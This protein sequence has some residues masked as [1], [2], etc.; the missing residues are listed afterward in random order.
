[1]KKLLVCIL[2]FQFAISG[3]AQQT[4][5]P[6]AYKIVVFA[7]VFIDSA[8][9]GNTYKINGNSL[10]KTILPGLDFYNGVMMAVDSLQ[11]EKA[12]IEVIFYDTKSVAE[13][14]NKVLSQKVWDIVSLIVVSFKDRQEI[15]PLADFALSKKIPLISATFPNEGGVSNNPY[16]VLLNSTLKTHCEGIYKFIQKNYSTSNLVYIKRKGKIED[17][18]LGIFSNMGKTT[19]AIPLK[20]KTI[21]LSDTFTIKQL[22]AYLDSTKQNVVICG[23]INETFGVRLVKALHAVKKYPAVA[24]GMPTW[25]GI[26]EF[27]KTIAFDEANKGIEIIYSTP[28]NFSKTEKLGKVLVEKYKGKYFARASDW[29]FKGYE[30]M[31]YFSNLL[32]KYNSD[33]MNHLSDADFRLFNSFDI[34]PVFASKQSTSPNFLENKKLYFVKKQD[35]VVKAVY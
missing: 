33:F 23:T 26:K 15:K 32:V 29:F 34:Q 22:Q 27:N 21:E 13:P 11:K 12:N 30:S 19:P 1:M 25:D 14:M 35:G 9:N 28:Y 31:Y 7:P 16:F 8:F 20:Y 24:I 2:F 6:S 3:F 18:I 4:S 10:P 5:Q 17:D